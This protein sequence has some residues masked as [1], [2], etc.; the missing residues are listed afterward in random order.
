[1]LACTRI[2]PSEGTKIQKFSGEGIQPS[3]QPLVQWGEKLPPHIPPLCPLAPRSSCLQPCFPSP[4]WKITDLPL[5]TFVRWRYSKLFCCNC[6]RSYLDTG[7]IWS[8]QNYMVW[9]QNC[10][11]NYTGSF[12]TTAV[13]VYVILPTNKQTDKHMPL[14]TTPHW[15]LLRWGND[16]NDNNKWQ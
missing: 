3:P 9:S 5:L 8:V 2:M 16:D 15:L 4:G 7:A 10:C 13:T 14:K 11:C 12:L 6:W 1:M